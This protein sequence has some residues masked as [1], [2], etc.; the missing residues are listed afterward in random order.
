PFD[1]FGNGE[2]VQ[3]DILYD[4]Y[5]GGSPITGDQYN[6]TITSDKLFYNRTDE[7]KLTATLSSDFGDPIDN[8]TITFTDITNNQI[9]G[10]NNTDINGITQITV[11]L[12]DSYIVGPHILE[13]RY[14]FFNYN[15]NV[16]VILG[17]IAIDLTI[18]NP[19]EV[20]RS[21]LIP[22][23]TFVQGYVYDPLNGK[24]V[25][26]AEVNFVLL[27]KGTSID[28]P[29]AFSPQSQITGNNGE[30]DT[31]LT[32][33]PS[34]S[35]GQYEIRVDFNGSWILYGISFPVGFITN[36]S[37]RIEFNIT[38]ALSVWLYID[39]TPADNPNIPLVPRNSSLSLIAIVMLENFGPKPNKEVYF[40]DYTRGDIQIGSAISDV[41]GIASINYFVDD[42]CISGPNLLYARVEIQVNYSYFI[43]DEV[44]T[45]N[46]ISG[47]TPQVI[48][49][50]GGGNTTFNVIGNITDATNS[51]RPLSYSEVSL[52]LISDGF[53]NS[54]YLVPFEGYPYQTGP[55]GTFD[56]TF[57]VDPSTPTGNYTLRMDFYG[58][59]DLT[60]NPYP[61]IFNLVS[62]SS[63]TVLDDELKIETP[64]VLYFD[65]WI[66]GYPSYDINNPI[67]N[68]YDT[69]NLS[70]LIQYD[71]TPIP[72]GEWVD[73]YDV[74][75]NSLMGSVQTTSGYAE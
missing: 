35:S 67:I 43:L 25:K 61:Y 23:E 71:S 68:R 22:D 31:T 60:G 57:A 4:S 55:T 17:D 52:R 10:V 1:Q 16:T 13:A 38:K 12:N 45:I 11:Q 50:T 20:N 48:N 49:R 65:F 26:D 24:R 7:M 56:L 39:G 42:Y 28:V 9:L 41:N 64:A 62:L 54:T 3:M 47:P 73:F 30:F 70:V 14:D 19:T 51:S 53:D 63:S 66:D 72:N 36:S 59:I 32:I 40:Y 29:F 5:G 18:V 21:D 46:I 8:R 75:Q 15:F 58:T 37:N 2:W 44:P 27:Q 6:I 33:N 69:L 74:T 34:V